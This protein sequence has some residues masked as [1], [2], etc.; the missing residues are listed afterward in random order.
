MQHITTNKDQVNGNNQQ[1]IAT[2]EDGEQQQIAT[3]KNGEQQQ[4][5]TNKKG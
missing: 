5:A 1:Q 2:N 4:I 3:N